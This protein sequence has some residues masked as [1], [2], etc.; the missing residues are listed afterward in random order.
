MLW[1]CTVSH[2]KSRSWRDSHKLAC[3][4][5]NWIKYKHAEKDFKLPW[6]Q[7]QHLLKPRQINDN[8]V[9]DMKQILTKVHLRNNLLF[10][11]E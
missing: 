7:F 10:T 8:N 5:E 9:S 11:L 3:C 1:V 2:A 6:V 4:V